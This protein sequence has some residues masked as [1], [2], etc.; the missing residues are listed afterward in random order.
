MAKKTSR[1]DFATAEQTDGALPAT[2]SVHEICGIKDAKYRHQTFAAY[3][4]YL[5]SLDLAALQ[6]HAY[7]FAVVPS[8]LARTMIMRLEDRFLRDYPEQ[9]AGVPAARLARLGK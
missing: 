5:R 6:D 1:L 2:L 8:P 4:T 7:E 9:R 3:Q